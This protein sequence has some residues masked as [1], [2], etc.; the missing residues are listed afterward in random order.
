LWYDCFI[1]RPLLAAPTAAEKEL[2][3]MSTHE[4]RMARYAHIHAT[5][6]ANIR[7]MMNFFKLGLIE[8]SALRRAARGERSPVR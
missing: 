4:A 6:L 3:K 5:H 7:P 2:L 1:D 8:G